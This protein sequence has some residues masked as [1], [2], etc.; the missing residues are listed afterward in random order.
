MD[1]SAFAKGEPCTEEWLYAGEPCKGGAKGERSCESLV[2]NKESSGDGAS[3]SASK[4]KVR[5]CSREEPACTPR[6]AYDFI[7]FSKLELM[8]NRRAKGN[9]EWWWLL[10]KLQVGKLR[11]TTRRVQVT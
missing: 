9:T 4:D 2:A 6:S 5:D 1:T 7:S 11:Q 10:R 8:V 3:K